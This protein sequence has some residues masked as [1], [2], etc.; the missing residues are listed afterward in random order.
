MVETIIKSAIGVIVSGALGYCISKIK[1]YKNAIKEKE[2]EKD[3]LK[4]AMMTMLQGSF[5]NTFYVYEELGKIPDYVYKNWLNQKKIYEEL[6]GNDYIHVLA[7][8]MKKWNFEKT[9]IL[10]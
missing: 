3:L 9:D 1:S 8:K 7:D 10:K 4:E 2:Q 6:G 5:T